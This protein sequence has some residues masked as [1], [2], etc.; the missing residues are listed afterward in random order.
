VLGVDGT[1][2]FQHLLIGDRQRIGYGMRRD[3]H[4]HPLRELAKAFLHAAAVDDEPAVRQFAQEDVGQRRHLRDY[5]QFLIDRRNAV[6]ALRARILERDRPALHFDVAGVGRARTR[7]HADEC[8]LAGAVGAD[9]PVH[10]ARLQY[11]AHLAQRLNAGKRLRNVAHADGERG[12]ADPLAADRRLHHRDHCLVAG[13]R[14]R[15]AR[16]PNGVATA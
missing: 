4:A 7:E 1:H 10:F 14:A 2:D 8:R 5:G 12:L 13:F 16:N 9:Q 3:F 11:K 6:V 15:T